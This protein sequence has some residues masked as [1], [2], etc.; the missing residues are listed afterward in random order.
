MYMTKIL[1]HLVMKRCNNIKN[2]II[3]LIPT[4]GLEPTT[5]RLEVERAI[6]CAMRVEQRFYIFYNLT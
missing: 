4:V 5:F 2:Y 6:H 3:N 1:K